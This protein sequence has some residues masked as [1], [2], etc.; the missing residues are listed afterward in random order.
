MYFFSNIIFWFSSGTLRYRQEKISLSN[1]MKR[2]P[3]KNEKNGGISCFCFPLLA[4]QGSSSKAVLSV[5]SGCMNSWACWLAF[6]VDAFVGCVW[7]HK[8]ESQAFRGPEKRTL[9][10]RECCRDF[11]EDEA[12][13]RN[14]TDLCLKFE[15]TMRCTRMKLTWKKRLKILHTSLWCKLPP[16]PLQPLGK[17]RTES[18]S[19]AKVWKLK[20][21]WNHGPQKAGQDFWSDLTGTTRCWNK[22]KKNPTFSR[23][24]Q[25]DSESHY[26][27]IKTSRIQC[28]TTQH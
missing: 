4:L 24:F 7:Q 8:T 1:K 26:T 13:E 18:N 21:H 17:H 12:Q 23:G 11:E 15:I 2:G 20:L 19:T 14:S 25:Q 16:R 3:L 9:S 10:A 6:K 5:G 28:K 22:T 27:A